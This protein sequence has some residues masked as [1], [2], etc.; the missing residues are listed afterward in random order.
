LDNWMNSIIT[1]VKKGIK[2]NE[3]KTGVNPEEFATFFISLIEGGI[4][5][6]KVTGSRIHL[7]RG[8]SLLIDKINNE[9]RA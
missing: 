8:V 4:M 1:I 7:E 5:L 2:R 3:I 9:L 6:S